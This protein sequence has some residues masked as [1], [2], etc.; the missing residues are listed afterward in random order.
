MAQIDQYFDLNDHQHKALE[1]NIDADLDRLRKE[2][3]KSFAKTLR[4]IDKSSR[5]SANVNVLS[6]GYALLKHHYEESNIYF[7]DAGAKLVASLSEQQIQSFKNKVQNEIL[8][9]KSSLNGSTNAMNEDLLNTYERALEF[10]FGDLTSEQKQSLVQFS[11]EHPYPWN[12]KIKNK[13]AILNKFMTLEKDPQKRREFSE[14]F[15]ADYDYMRTPEYATAVDRYEKSFQSYLDSF[16]NLLSTEQK[17]RMHG[18]L[19]GRAEKLEQMAK[20][21]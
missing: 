17:K 12:E 14:Q 8:T 21:P 11:R 5:G 7:K 2:R 20:K 9:M 6:S 1:K 16:W 3:F 15:I 18:Y 4:D 19:I 10:W 13:E